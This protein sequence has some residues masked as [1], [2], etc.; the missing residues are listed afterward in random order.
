[1][2]R[3]AQVS[4]LHRRQGGDLESSWLPARDG[5]GLIPVS[6]AIAR[7][8]SPRRAA[9]ALA[10]EI[11]RVQAAVREKRA[12]HAGGS[13][14]RDRAANSSLVSVSPALADG[15]LAAGCVKFGPFT[16][17][18][19]LQSPVYL[20]LRLLV[21][22]P[23]LLSEVGRA[24]VPVLRGLTFDRIAALPYAALPIG[25]AV[26]LAGG[27]PMIYPRREAKSYGTGAEI[28]GE[29]HSGERVVVI[30]DLATTGDKPRYIQKL[31]TGTCR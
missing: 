13:V 31:E 21:S 2:P 27:W 9:E 19:G 25:A 28:E 3:C 23:A 15:I 10:D 20:D 4:L 11:R 26:S 24:Y 17:K 5:L 29:Y 8:A 7:A 30:D 1:M 16:L 14:I 12:A 22:H 6:R 18:S